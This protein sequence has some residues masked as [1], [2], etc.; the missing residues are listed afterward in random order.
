MKLIKK[1]LSF[2]IGGWL[3]AVVGLVTIPLMTRL[4]TPEEFGKA[5]M[6]ALALNVLMLFVTFGID[7]AFVRFFYEENTKKLLIKCLQLT[8]IV[9]LCSVVIIYC[10]KIQISEYLFG[11]YDLKIIAFLS[12][13]SFLY[14]LNNYAI[15]V[16]RMKQMSWQYSIAQFGLRIFELIF[17]VLFFYL[18]GKD[19]S[20][21]VYA[22]I[23][24][25]LFVT[26]LAMILSKSIWV[27]KSSLTPT[28]NSSRKDIVKYSYPLAITSILTWLLQSVDKISI[29]QWSSYKELGIYMAAFRIM[30]IMDILGSSFSVYWTPLALERFINKTPAENNEFYKQANA[31]VSVVML[32]ATTIIIMF[33]DVVVLLLGHNYRNVSSIMPLLVFMPLMYIVS[34]TTV[35]GINFHK[36]VRWHLLISG[37]VL[38]VSVA[39]NAV[40][41]PHLG[42]KG[43]AMSIA[44]AY[45]CYFILR[46]HISLKYY[47]VNYLLQKFYVAAFVLFLYALYSA[48]FSWN[49]LNVLFGIGV[50]LMMLQLY[51]SIIK[52]SVKLL[53]QKK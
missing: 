13:A 32:I 16:L 9:Y 29:K 4:F 40:L 3:G 15:S 11:Y 27:D 7:Q 19:Y 49:Y 51:S 10:F 46:T 38:V 28:I 37:S 14:V 42:S 20:T 45:V 21:I 25:M 44:I 1:F 34:E 6:F 31:L 26:I 36:K 17:I 22:K 53:L 43:A 2:S 30:A 18:L 35:I 33:K 5:S 8:F 47:K 39:S 41:V 12:A 52:S 48:F 24:T 23:A 50:I